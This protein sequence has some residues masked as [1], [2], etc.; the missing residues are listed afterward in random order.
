M[1]DT[2]FVEQPLAPPVSSKKCNQGYVRVELTHRKYVTLSSVLSGA[3]GGWD[4]AG[5]REG[6]PAI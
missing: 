3:G 5:P 4:E 2:L 1:N 6:R